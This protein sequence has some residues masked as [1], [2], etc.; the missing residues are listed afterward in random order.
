MSYEMFWDSNSWFEIWI[1]NWSIADLLG[2]I[3]G[4]KSW[5]DSRVKEEDKIEE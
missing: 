3:I 2:M 4:A 1:L 5:I